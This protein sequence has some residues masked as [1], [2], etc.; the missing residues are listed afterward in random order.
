MDYRRD[1][2]SRKNIPQ[3]KEDVYPVEDDVGKLSTEREVLEKEWNEGRFYVCVFN[4]QFV[5][6]EILKQNFIAII[7]SNFY[8]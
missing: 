2:Q 6:N 7:L 8:S 3:L 4:T 1:L 5:V